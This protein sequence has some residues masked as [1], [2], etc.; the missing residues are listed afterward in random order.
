[1]NG[2]LVDT[3]VISELVKPS[4]HNNII[5]FLSTLSNAWLSVIT[6][7][8]LDY[9]LKLMPKGKRRSNLEQK[10]RQ[11][12]SEYGGFVIPIDKLEASHAASFRV[13]ARQQGRVMHLADSLIAG[14][15]KVHNLSL[16]TR[17][18]NDFTGVDIEIINPWGN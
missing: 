1:M 15:A 2:C 3:N 16:A 11:L 18:V 9:G 14:T 17:N 8:E 4:P 5:Q 13:E 6:L 12:L 7:H 10:L